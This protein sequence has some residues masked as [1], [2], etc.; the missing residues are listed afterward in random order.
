ML[1]KGLRTPKALEVFHNL[2][3]DT[4]TVELL[5]SESE[6]IMTEKSPSSENTDIDEEVDDLSVPGPFRISKV[7]WKNKVS[8]KIRRLP[9]IEQ[10]GDPQ[11]KQ[12]PFKILHRNQFFLTLFS[13]SFIG[14]ICTKRIYM[15]R[16]KTVH[17]LLL[18]YRI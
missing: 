4:E 7:T 18:L 13:I 2:P 16:K 8:V 12:H 10:K 11:R 9:F 1:R 5:L 17:S 3:S 6:D 15:L 14:T